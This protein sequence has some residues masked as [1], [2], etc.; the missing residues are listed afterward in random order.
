MTT[1]AETKRRAGLRHSERRPPDRLASLV[2]SAASGDA[3]A[4]SEIVEEFE[5]LLWAVAQSH[6]LCHADAADV[7]QTTWLRLA[8][9]LDRLRSPGRVGA[10]LTTTARRECLR[11]L[12]ASARELPDAEPPDLADS[13]APPI[14]GHLIESER[15]AA[16]QS[17]LRRLPARDRTLLLM[18][19]DDSG[20]SYEEIGAA[21]RMPIGSIGPTRGR[22]LDRL[23]GELERRDALVKLAA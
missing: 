21:L 22:A 13:E 14:D 4:W 11:A 19:V 1:A 20:P 8:E 15:A 17:A 3:H 18:L 12:T 7:V 23:R 5:G 9:N 2:R 16:I 10:W 6:R